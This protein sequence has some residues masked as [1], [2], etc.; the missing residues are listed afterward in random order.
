MQAISAPDARKDDE[1]AAATENGVAS[2]GRICTMHDTAVD[3][4]AL[5]PVFLQSLPCLA[6]EVECDRIHAMLC[7]FI[8]G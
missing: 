6:D 8:E 4:A 3:C 5:L 2:L 1:F 7:A